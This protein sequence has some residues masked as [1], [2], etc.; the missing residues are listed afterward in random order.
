MEPCVNFTGGMTLFTKE[1]LFSKCGVFMKW[2]F[3]L[4]A[5]IDIEQTTKVDDEYKGRDRAEVNHPDVHPFTAG[6]R[7]VSGLDTDTSK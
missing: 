2:K 1:W 4:W 6:T 7:P 3:Y 5:R